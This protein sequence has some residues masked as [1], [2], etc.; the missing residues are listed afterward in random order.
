MV[1]HDESMFSGQ[2]GVSVLAL[3]WLLMCFR[4]WLMVGKRN[5]GQRHLLAIAGGLG[6]GLIYVLG[7]LVIGLLKAP[8]KREAEMRDAPSS[9]EQIRIA[10]SVTPRE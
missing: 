6:A 9:G 1:P 7:L 2:L 5:P 4:F 8:T 3:L 10:P